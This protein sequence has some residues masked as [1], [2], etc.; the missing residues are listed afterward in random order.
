MKTIDS[1]TH[2]TVWPFRRLPIQQIRNNYAMQLR[3][4]RRQRQEVRASFAIADA[5]L[6]QR[7]VFKAI[8]EATKTNDE[9]HN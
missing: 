2:E 7:D 3:A 6:S 5:L 4:E 1:S 9:K 8:R